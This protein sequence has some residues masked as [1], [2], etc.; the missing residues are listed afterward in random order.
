M[1]P[2]IVGVTAIAALIQ[3]AHSAPSKP[4]S[5][6]GHIFKRAVLRF[7]DC[8]DDKDPKRIKAGQAFE[9]AATLAL[10]TTE[11]L[12]AFTDSQA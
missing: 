8:G 9:D 1:L 3:L 10:F 2:S 12:D 6:I 7:E 11:N 4:A 5:S